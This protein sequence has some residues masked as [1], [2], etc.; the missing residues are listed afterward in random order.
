MKVHIV[1]E[2]GISAN[3]RIELEDGT[4]LRNVAALSLLFSIGKVVQAEA[5]FV[6]PRVDVI[7]HV[8]V[9]EEHL[10]DLA[11]AHGYELKRR[12]D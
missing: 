9:T 8:T 2:D 12:S 11:A 1:S 4:P 7:G 6:L 3:T 5:T 10:R